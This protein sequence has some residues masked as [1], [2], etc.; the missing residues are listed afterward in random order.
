MSATGAET[1]SNLVPAGPVL[2]TTAAATPST[3][4]IPAE[5]TI[6]E[7]DAD[8]VGRSPRQLLRAVIAGILAVLAGAVAWLLLRHGVRTD[9]FPPFLTGSQATPITR[10]SGPW[11]TAAAGA[12][13]LAALLLLSALFDV[14]RWSRAAPTGAG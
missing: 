11:I 1:G 14:I 13:L 6:G 8:A 4:I 12:A 10:Y 3:G 9:S 7:P 2:A 5:P